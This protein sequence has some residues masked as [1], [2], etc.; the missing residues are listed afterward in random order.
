VPGRGAGA[1]E[2]DTA[3]AAGE[4]GQGAEAAAQVAARR[5]PALAPAEMVVALSK[6]LD[7]AEGRPMGHAH[8]VCYI[9]L[10][11]GRSLELSDPALLALFYASLFHDL[12]VPL[13]SVGLTGVAGSDDALFAGAPLR[14]PESLAGEAPPPVFQAIVEAFHKH[15]ELGAQAASTFGLSDEAADAIRAHHEQW[16]GTGYP[17]GLAGRET[18]LLARVLATSDRMESL[19]W[20]EPNALAARRALL[21]VLAE[22]SGRVLEPVLVQRAQELCRRDDFW[23]GLYD[24]GLPEAL[25][26]MKPT[27]ATS[28]DKGH[29]V[30]FAEAFADV[31][32]ARSQ[33]TMGHSRQVA[34]ASQR[35]AQALGFADEHVE[36]IRVAA[37]LHDVGLLGVPA[38]VLEKADVLD[39]S[40]MQLLRL[41]PSYSRQILEG[42]PGLAEIASWVEA[43]H[44]RPDGRGYPEML[45]GRETPLEAKILSVADVHSAL[46]SERPYRAALS[47]EDAIKVLRG[48]AG[49]QLDPE[50]VSV[51]CPLI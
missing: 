3:R 31:V 12:G 33:H 43:H 30:R 19:I 48:A 24:I 35:L 47:R 29:V 49:G 6:G 50:L 7:L 10:A 36:C 8:R 17:S 20:A 15:C 32:D 14:S 4:A 45:D 5:L 42:L 18:P 38:R 26:A 1:R 28:R 2:A 34:A 25:L 37:L 21:P 9:A 51:Y 23:L 16:D 22:Q 41:H 11:L 46:T 13:A 39:L 27:E 44:E 40:E